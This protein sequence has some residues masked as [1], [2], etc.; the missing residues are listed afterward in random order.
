MFAPLQEDHLMSGIPTDYGWR[1]NEE[2]HVGARQA[3]FHKEGTFL[4]PL[5]RFPGAFFDANGYILFRTPEEFYTNRYIQIGERVNVPEGISNIPGYC[6]MSAARKKHP[7]SVLFKKG[8]A[9]R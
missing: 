7:S 1:L 5:E 2:W 4:M 3:L 8:K 6:K 9:R